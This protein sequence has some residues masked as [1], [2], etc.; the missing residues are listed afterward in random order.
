MTETRPDPLA[1]PHGHPDLDTLA[2]FDA[3]VLAPAETTRLEAHVSSCAQCQAV[4]AGMSDVSG[5]LRGLPPPRMPAEVEARIFAA[6]AAERAGSDPTRHPAAASVL[7]LDAARERRR[8]RTRVMSIAAAG[9]IVVVGGAAT[10][11]GL[12]RSS[13]SGA[14]GSAV[15]ER[16][17]TG[18]AAGPGLTGLP[19]YDRETITR[20]PLLLSILNG[21]RGTLAEP[22][23]G[24][25][26]DARR[27]QAC[28]NGIAREVQGINTGPAGVQHIRFEGQQAYL[29]VYSGTS[30]RT[31]VV[32]G[33][34]C[35]TADP[36]V[37]YTRTL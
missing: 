5:L 23:G 11:I 24:A 26:S 36:D 3:G 7:N 15:A 27:L 2:D 33:E 12:N 10:A 30:A 20:S 4:I 6:L 34:K 32:V 9:L 19:S 14:G 29:L 18:K 25:M 37:L 28:E 21:D 1:S 13:P 16:D 31:L 35:S 8:R 17:N 22:D